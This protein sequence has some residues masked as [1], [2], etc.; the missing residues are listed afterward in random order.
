MMVQARRKSRPRQPKPK[1]E[2]K[3]SGNHYRG[4][5][6][7]F[8]GMLIGSLATI[9]WQGTQTLDGNVGGGIRGLVEIFKED[10][11]AAADSKVVEEKSPKK[12]STDFTFFTVLPEIEVVT[13]VVAETD[14][15]SSTPTETESK[16]GDSYMLQAGSYRHRKDADSLKATLAL[17]GMVSTIQKVTIEGRGDFYRVRLGPYPN[18]KAMTK[19][20]EQ[21]IQAG[22]KAL[23]LK[24]FKA[25]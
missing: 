14:T 8:A 15:S 11:N 13:P 6:M 3:K 18:Y 2:R 9:L 1:T 7:L 22:I 17:N 25:G 23:R 16:E 10:K 24:M 4:I 12:Q 19:A 20:D 21:L 5:V